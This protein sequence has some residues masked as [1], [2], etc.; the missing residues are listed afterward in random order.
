MLTVLLL[1]YFFVII[2][3]QVKRASE[4]RVGVLTQCLKFRTLEKIN[5]MTVKNILLKVNSKLRGVN[6]CLAPNWK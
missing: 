4:L 5:A 2:T 3:G 1:F 6:H